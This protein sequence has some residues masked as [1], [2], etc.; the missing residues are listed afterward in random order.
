MRD[1]ISK[2]KK[3]L[4]AF[5]SVRV[6]N[7]SKQLQHII[8][9]CGT[10]DISL[11]SSPYL[12]GQFLLLPVDSLSPPSLSRNTCPLR[13][14]ADNM[15]RENARKDCELARVRAIADAERKRT[16]TL[17][18]QA[19]ELKQALVEELQEVDRAVNSKLREIRNKQEAIQKVSARANRER[20]RSC[21]LRDEIVKLTTAL[22]QERH[23]DVAKTK[24]EYGP[25]VAYLSEFSELSEL[26]P[27]PSPVAPNLFNDPIE[28][29]QSPP[30]RS[31][32][33]SLGGAS[34]S[35]CLIFSQKMKDLE[36]LEKEKTKR[37]EEL[38]K[39]KKLAEAERC[40]HLLL[41][42]KM[43]ELKDELKSMN[44]REMSRTY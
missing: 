14:E 29:T 8:A 12:Q 39:M 42:D 24:N 33:L 7:K 32:A 5:V 6:D 36:L 19:E 1:Q 16:D 27:Q 4:E 2:L 34:S 9:S 43:Q 3:S 10:D 25:D 17:K 18:E 13:V 35:E 23:V 26:D 30:C 22:A 37:D 41:R 40:R 11:S 28:I 15:V 21:F 38:T 44:T 20:S 31:I